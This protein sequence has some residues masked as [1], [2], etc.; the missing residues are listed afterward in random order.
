MKY[1]MSLEKLGGKEET[2]EGTRERACGGE[3][4]G[5]VWRSE[6]EVEVVVSVGVGVG[7]GWDLLELE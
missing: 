1:E 7:V 6:N 4:E 3:N 2:R 5:K